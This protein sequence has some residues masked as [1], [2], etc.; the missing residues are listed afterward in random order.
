MFKLSKDFLKPP[1]QEVIGETQQP[2][3]AKVITYCKM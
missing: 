1:S 3:W 2:A